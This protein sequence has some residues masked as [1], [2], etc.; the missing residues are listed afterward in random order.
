MQRYTRSASTIALGTWSSPYGEGRP[1]AGDVV[2]YEIGTGRLSPAGVQVFGRAGAR[3]PG[4]GY[5]MACRDDGAVAIVDT[6]GRET[7]A[8][9]KV[10][11][12]DGT[13]TRLGRGYLFVAQV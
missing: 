9:L 2:G 3:W 6:V 11:R 7:P 4:G 13:I 12:P 1:T 5:G 8:D 10:I